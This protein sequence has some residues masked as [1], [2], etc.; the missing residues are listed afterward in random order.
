MRILPRD[1]R[2]PIP[3]RWLFGYG[4]VILRIGRFGLGSNP[5]CP[6]SL[7]CSLRAVD[8]LRLF[9]RQRIFVSRLDPVT[10]S[11]S[12]VPPAKQIR[13]EYDFNRL[14]EFRLC[15]MPDHGGELPVTAS[16]FCLFRNGRHRRRGAL[17][18]KTGVARLVLG[19]AILEFSSSRISVGDGL[20]PRIQ[21]ADIY[22]QPG[23]QRG[24]HPS[25]ASIDGASRSLTAEAPR[26]KRSETVGLRA[27][28]LVGS[29][30]KSSDECVR[31]GLCIA[32]RKL[33]EYLSSFPPHRP[34]GFRPSPREATTFSCPLITHLRTSRAFPSAT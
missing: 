15:R 34:F 7:A 16:P 1:R 8:W 31:R 32:R 11:S 18:T 9:E 26:R 25:A 33:L 28:V 23:S 2:S 12:R 5:V 6:A 21:H 24:K 17:L 14:T 13:G 27:F 19:V 4:S 20:D 22:R 3:R 29:C 10:P 30:G